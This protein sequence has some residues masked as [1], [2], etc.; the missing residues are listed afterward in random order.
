MRSETS[1]LLTQNSPDGGSFVV[2]IPAGLVSGQEFR[3]LP[4][5]APTQPVAE[6]DST[7]VMQ[8]EFLPA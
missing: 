4:P 7:V 3:V 2:T 6:V 1:N 8:R 5:P